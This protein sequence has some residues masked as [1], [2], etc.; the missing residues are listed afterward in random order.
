MHKL[1]LLFF[2]SRAII[3]LDSEIQLPNWFISYYIK[4]YKQPNSRTFSDKK[5]TQHSTNV[6]LHTRLYSMVMSSNLIYHCIF[7]H[8]KWR[9]QKL[10][11]NDSNGSIAYVRTVFDFFF[12]KKQPKIELL[13]NPFFFV[14]KKKCRFFPALYD[15]LLIKR[16]ALQKKVELLWTT[17]RSYSKKH[18]VYVC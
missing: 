7:Y 14:S 3:E 5:H 4:L 13:K 10:F 9:V 17:Q 8:T 1:C 11:I 16:I 6:R 18:C 12:W 2:F 15:L